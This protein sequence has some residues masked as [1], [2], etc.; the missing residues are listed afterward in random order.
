MKIKKIANIV[1][2]T[3]LVLTLLIVATTVFSYKFGGGEPN[4][5]GYQFKVVLSG[6]MEPSIK[7]GSIIATTN[8]EDPSSL[9]EGDVITYHTFSSRDTLITHR[10]VEVQ[11]SGGGLQFITKGD[12]NDAIDPE[13]IPSSHVVAKYANFTIPL[14]GYAVNFSNTK[15]GIILLLIVPG[16]IILVT[17]VINVWR[18]IVHGVEEEELAGEAS[19]KEVIQNEEPQES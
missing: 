18:I 1:I 11:E 19:S 3:L 13:P 16:F 7:T 5:F 14:V 15:T 9:R 10:I 2:N 6:S 17:Q 8:V 12:N 4:L